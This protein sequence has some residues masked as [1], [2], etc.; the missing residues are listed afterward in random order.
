MSPLFNLI[1]SK[2]FEKQFDKL[3]DKTLQ[4]RV[5]KKVLTL[6]S[7]PFQGK[8]LTAMEDDILGNLFRIRIGD[9]R[10]VYG[11]NQRTNEIY[12]VTLGHRRNIYDTID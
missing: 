7:N 1:F 4:K 8:R 10:V 9:F 5:L 6:K 2:E 3:G 11:I 12:L